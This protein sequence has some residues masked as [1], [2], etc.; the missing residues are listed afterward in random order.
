MDCL[1]QVA[2]GAY[3]SRIIAPSCTLV[4]TWGVWNGLITSQDHYA[5]II[6]V[7]L[8]WLPT[9]ITHSFSPSWISRMSSKIGLRPWRWRGGLCLRLRTA[10]RSPSS[11]S[12]LGSSSLT[13]GLAFA[14]LSNAIKTTRGDPFLCSWAAA[15][16]YYVM[17]AINSILSNSVENV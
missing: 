1:S 16:C 9:C 3:L 13:V 8:L 12:P 5:T 4:V 10:S 17:L 7:V 14:H 15:E 6:T 11:D 2:G